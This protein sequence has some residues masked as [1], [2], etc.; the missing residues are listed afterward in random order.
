VETPGD[1]GDYIRAAVRAE[2][3]D[4]MALLKA[5]AERQKSALPGIQAK[6][7]EINRNLAFKGEWIEV[8]KS[9]GNFQWEQKGE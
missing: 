4:R 6:Q 8:E 9:P 7:A 1:Y 5:E 3:A 2:N